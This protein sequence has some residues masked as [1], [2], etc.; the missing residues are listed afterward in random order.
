MMPVVTY[1]NGSKKILCNESGSAWMDGA[2]EDNNRLYFEFRSQKDCSSLGTYVESGDFDSGYSGEPIKLDGDNQYPVMAAS[3]E[4]L[5]CDVGSTP[6]AS[7]ALK[8]EGGRV[9]GTMAVNE[10]YISFP[11]NT[12]EPFATA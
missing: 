8:F 9:I 2:T 4:M 6:N 5:S 12:L 1:S 3:Y 10:D 11:Y 7:I